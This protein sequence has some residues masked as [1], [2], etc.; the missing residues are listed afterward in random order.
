MSIQNYTSF[1]KKLQKAMFA[2]LDVQESLKSYDEKDVRYF[3]M[4]DPDILTILTNY[5]TTIEIVSKKI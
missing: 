5:K 1:K 3:F 4:E 2:N